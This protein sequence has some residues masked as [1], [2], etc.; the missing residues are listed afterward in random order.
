MKSQPTTVRF[1]VS[2]RA[3]VARI[4]R[5]VAKDQKQFIAVRSKS[6]R[7][8]LGPWCVT[9]GQNLVVNYSPEFTLQDW[10]KQ[11]EALAINEKIED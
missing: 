9:Q 5:K 10:A 11:F 1:T 4:N 3:I 7:K 6:D 8:I 2:K